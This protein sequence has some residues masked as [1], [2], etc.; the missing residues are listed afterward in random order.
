MTVKEL[1]EILYKVDESATVLLIRQGENPLT[2]GAD[3]CRTFNVEALEEDGVVNCLL[4][5]EYGE[6]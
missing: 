3:I 2:E 1:M 6:V 5:L 4:V